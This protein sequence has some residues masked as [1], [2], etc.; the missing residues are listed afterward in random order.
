MVVLT[1][2]LLSR[3]APMV[4]TVFLQ[5]PGAATIK[6]PL[7]PIVLVV[8]RVQLGPIPR[9]YMECLMPL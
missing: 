9:L 3:L 4:L 2:D 6:L 5:N 8:V 7:D 1:N